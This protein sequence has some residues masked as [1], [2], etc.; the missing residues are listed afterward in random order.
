VL[1]SF[2]PSRDEAG[3]TLM[4]V[5]VASAILMSVLAMLFGILV[6]L[7][8]SEQRTSAVVAN[9]QAVRFVMNDF[10]RDIRAG[11]PITI[12]PGTTGNA[13]YATTLEM[14]LGPDGA[15]DIVRWTYDDDDTS[16]TYG[17]LTRT[18]DGVSTVRLQRVKNA[19]RTPPVV[20]LRYYDSDGDEL[21]PP[22]SAA[23]IA[24]CSVR[25]RITITA[26]SEPGPEP[27]TETMDV[28]LRNR[29]PGGLGC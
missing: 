7:T 23:T 8:R 10:A 17:N 2:R 26:D 15:K 22:N 4:E 18:V 20:M 19:E 11:N 24:N 6:S 3:M 28:H 12:W 1:K 16:P 27:F 5:M 21:A 14:Q 9:E 13:L 25:V 29:L